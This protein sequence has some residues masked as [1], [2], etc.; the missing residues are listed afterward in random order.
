MINKGGEKI[1]P[2]ELDGVVLRHPAVVEAAA[3]AVVD[4]LYGQDVAVAVRV[5]EGES[6][7]GVGLRRWVRGRVA[8][9]KVPT[10]VCGVFIV[11]LVFW[12]F[13]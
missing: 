10:K 13:F 11:C 4:G 8:G 6:I 5:G 1:S 12:F 9:F 2:A 3:F 7:D